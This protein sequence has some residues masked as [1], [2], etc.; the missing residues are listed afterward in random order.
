MQSYLIYEAS[1]GHVT[2]A[3]V[4]ESC[5]FLLSNVPTLPR[6]AAVTLQ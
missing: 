1:A 3:D 6:C 4:R 5:G 2:R